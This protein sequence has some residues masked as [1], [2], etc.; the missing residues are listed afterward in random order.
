[1]EDGKEKEK[2]GRGRELTGEKSSKYVYVVGEQISATAWFNPQVE[3]LNPTLIN[4]W[5]GREWKKERSMCAR[6]GLVAEVCV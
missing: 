6:E 4:L 3:G 5:K 2:G 1:M